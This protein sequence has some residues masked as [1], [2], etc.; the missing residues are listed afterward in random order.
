M[1]GLYGSN[2]PLS[3]QAIR[4]FRVLCGKIENTAHVRAFLLPEASDNLGPGFFEP[5]LIVTAEISYRPTRR[6]YELVAS[7][8]RRLVALLRRLLGTDC[9]GEVKPRQ[10]DGTPHADE[11]LY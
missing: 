9:L 6:V 5:R 4:D 10:T 3:R 7:T 11:S 8:R 1:R 2:P